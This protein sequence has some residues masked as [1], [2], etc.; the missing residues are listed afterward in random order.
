MAILMSLYNVWCN[1][2]L[3]GE[4][5]VEFRNNI[6]KDFKKGDTIY[7]YETSK[8]KG[9]KKVVGEVT[10]KDI[11]PIPR[12]KVGTYGMLRYYIS[13]ILKDED[14][15][16]QLDI[17]LSYNIPGFDPIIKVDYMFMPDKMEE[18]FLNE[19]ITSDIVNLMNFHTK[20]VNANLE[21]SQQ[22]M[23]DCD[24]WLKDIGYYNECDETNYRN[25]IE[26]E[27][28][29]CYEA[30]RDLSDFTNLKGVTINKAPQSWC[31]VNK[32]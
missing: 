16:K 2:I 10:I 31:Y 26:L 11:Q 6:G 15:L 29:I 30:P 22:L 5:T 9:R 23:T 24:N 18:R 27:N 8:N 32:L 3:S 7:L 21:K 25:Y 13:N 17:A 28:P 4:K 20:E 14:L 12:S 19:D 1:K